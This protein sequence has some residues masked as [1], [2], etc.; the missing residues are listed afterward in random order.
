MTATTSGK[1]ATTGWT[2]G[3]GLFWTLTLALA[4]MALAFL[5]AIGWDTEAIGW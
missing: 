4:A 1:P 2:E 5:V 3:W